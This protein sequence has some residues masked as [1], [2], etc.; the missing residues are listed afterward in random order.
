MNNCATG[1]VMGGFA[2][3]ETHSQ[4]TLMVQENSFNIIT[5]K[6]VRKLYVFYV[7]LR[8]NFMLILGQVRLSRD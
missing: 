5:I 7:F 1:N 4:H 2:Q 6:V 3:K 8:R